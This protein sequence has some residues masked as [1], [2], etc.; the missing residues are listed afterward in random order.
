[1]PA[2]RADVHRNRETL[3]RSAAELFAARGSGIPLAEIAKHAGLGVGTLYRHFPSRSELVAATYQREIERLAVTDDLLGDHSGADALAIWLGRFVDFAE[4]KGAIADVLHAPSP[5]AQPSA[6]AD[7][8]AA[9]TAILGHGAQ[10]G[11][12]RDDVDADDV[13]FSTSG[14]WLGQD[15]PDWRP[16]AERLVRLIGDGLRR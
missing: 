10:D 9:I 2:D 3:L 13:L 12:L 6:R 14:L 7:V 11:T 15:A 5:T 4:A 8:I 16:R 1:M